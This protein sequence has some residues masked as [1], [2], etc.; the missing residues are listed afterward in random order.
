[1]AYYGN[2]GNLEYDFIL[3]PGADPAAIRLKANGARRVHVEPGGDL[4]LETECG[5]VR[6]HKP[7][8][9][10]QVNGA[11]RTVESRYELAGSNEIQ[12][13]L[14]PYDRHYQLVVD[15]TLAY[16]TYLGG[17]GYNYGQAVAVGPNGNAFVTGY[18]SSTDFP[19]VN[20]NRF[21]LR[22][23]RRSSSQNC[24]QTDPAWSIPL[25][26]QAHRTTLRTRSPW[27]A[28]TAPTLQALPNLPAS[29]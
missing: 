7:V 20:P 1:L 21:S 2:Q 22:D 12:F 17:T 13:K 24:L 27:I 15:P 18:T 14:G 4:V 6:F 19:T 23:F 11:R 8:S 16:S 9:Y 25:T 26:W 5:D 10:Q 29:R 3:S 28:L